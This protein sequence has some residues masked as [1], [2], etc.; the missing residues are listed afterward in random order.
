LGQTTDEELRNSGIKSWPG[1]TTSVH[2]YRSTVK[3]Y[4]AAAFKRVL[5]ELKYAAFSMNHPK[6]S[7]ELVYS[8]IQTVY[9]PNFQEN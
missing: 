5:E 2:P 4:G 7:S 6:V 9:S 3:L 1:V 8:L